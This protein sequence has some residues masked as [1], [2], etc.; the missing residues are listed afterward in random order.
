MYTSEALLLL[1]VWTVLLLL[2][3]VET[4]TQPERSVSVQLCRCQR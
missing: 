2:L 3:H 1:D 4:P